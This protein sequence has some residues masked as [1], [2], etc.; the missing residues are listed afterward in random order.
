MVSPRF[1]LLTTVLVAIALALAVR[2]LAKRESPWRLDHTLR[3][4]MVGALSI[5][6][7]THVENC[8]RAGYLP[9]PRQPF[10]FNLYWTSLTLFDPLAAVLLVLR[11][12]AG[13]VMS[14]IIM[15]SDI[16]INA[17]AF[18]PSGALSMEWPFWLQVTFASFLLVASPYCWRSLRLR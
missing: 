7:C 12:R 13:L 18:R 10:V 2:L 15:L 8:W 11:P 1:V 9:L 14:A 5:G 3:V 16:A 6:T 4:L 17:Y